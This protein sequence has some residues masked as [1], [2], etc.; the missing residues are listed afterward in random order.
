MF[1]VFGSVLALKI[2]AEGTKVAGGVV[3]VDH[4]GGGDR[5]EQ[6]VSRSQLEQSALID[7]VQRVLCVWSPALGP[8]AFQQLY[9]AGVGCFLIDALH[10]LMAHA[11]LVTF[12][13]CRRRVSEVNLRVQVVAS[14]LWHPQFA[15][16]QSH[17]VQVS[18]EALIGPGPDH[19][20]TG[21]M[22]PWGGHWGNGEPLRTGVAQGQMSRRPLRH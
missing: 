21:L 2:Q 11:A 8:D 5:D 6:L 15:V 20:A 1:S 16:G 14:V 4:R 12:S 18:S 3:R 7:R 22:K 17:V 13:G 10:Q 19:M 9:G